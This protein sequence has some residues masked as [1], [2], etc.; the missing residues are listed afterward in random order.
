[1]LKLIIFILLTTSNALFADVGGLAD[2]FDKLSGSIL[3]EKQ[4]EDALIN[5]D[6]KITEHENINGKDS[7][8]KLYVETQSNSLG[9]YDKNIKN[10]NNVHIVD[11]GEKDIKK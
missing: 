8:Y 3:T 1:M 9:S 6:K 7:A 2:L 4:T 11:I 5:I 10:E